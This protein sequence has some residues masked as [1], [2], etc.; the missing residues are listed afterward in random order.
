MTSRSRNFF[1]LLLVAGLFFGSLAVISST[2][3]RQGLDLKGGT[4]LIYQ[5][6]PTK[7][8]KVDAES[9]KHTL[10]IMRSRVDQLGVSEPE[11]TSLG[12]DQISVALPDVSNLNRA[13][14]EVGKVA[15]MHFYDWEA[16]LLYPPD[17]KPKPNQPNQADGSSPATS[18]LPGGH[19]GEQAPGDAASQRDDER[20]LVRGR[21]RAAEG[22]LRAERHARRTPR[23]TAR[24]SSSAPRTR[25]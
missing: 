21:H 13:E 10:D 14:Q 23:R 12:R 22:H 8:A 16:N 9:I 6:K 5:A 4:S 20:R 19:A 24:P 17:L 7:Q 11:I 18:L 2:K 1:V 25:A 15:Q 3:T